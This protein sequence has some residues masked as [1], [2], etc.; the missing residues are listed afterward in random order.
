MNKKAIF[1]LLIIFIFTS[2]VTA[3]AGAISL[4]QTGQ[5]TSYRAGDDGDLERG[6]VSPS[7]R[8]TDNGNGTVADNLTGLMWTKN[9][10]LPNGT[11]TWQVALDYVKSLNSSNYLGYSDWRLPNRKELRSLIDYSEYDPSLPI[12][13]PFTNV[14]LNYY[15]S[16]STNA[17]RTESAWMVNMHDGAVQANEAYY[18]VYYVWPVR[19]GQTNENPTAITLSSFK[20]KQ[21]GRK[22]LVNWKTASEVDNL[23]FNILRSDSENGTY[24]QINSDLIPAKK[25][26]V[27]GANYKFKDRDIEKGNT[28]WY[29]LEDI[30]KTTGSTVHDAV[31][32]KTQIR[33]QVRRNTARSD[34]VK[35][36]HGD[37]GGKKDKNLCELCE[38]RKN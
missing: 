17:S 19:S 5:T 3:L 24:T 4:P 15:W 10:N 6:V 22:I 31:E 23:G 26:A 30:D 16:S 14:Q 18:D 34:A 1:L 32:G 35:G 36:R 20:A 21:S 37:A 13:H 33:K 38:M 9:A 2:I 28:Y 11:K 12:G 25:N 29:K 7:P 8:F 27:S